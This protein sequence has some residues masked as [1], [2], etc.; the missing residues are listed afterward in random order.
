M[1]RRDMLIASASIA[2][3]NKAAI[4]TSEFPKSD[5]SIRYVVPFAPGGLT[6]VMARTVAQK[7]AEAWRISVVVENKAGASGQIGAEQVA[8]SAS[9][10]SNLLAITSNHAVNVALFPNATY[11]LVKDLRPVALLANSPM[12][13]VVPASSPLNDFRDLMAASKTRLLA[14]GSSSNGSATHLTMALFNDVNQ[15][16]MTHV[17]YKG[18]APSMLDLIS[19]RLDVIFSNFPESIAHVKAGKLRALAICSSARHHVVPD[20][21]TTSE[22]GMPELN[23]ESWT[24]VMLP[25]KAPDGV[26]DRYSREISRIMRMADVQERVKSQGF[27]LNFQ[28]PEEFAQFLTTEISRWGRIIK[29]GNISP[30]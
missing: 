23:V 22:A 24:G 25:A 10:G 15:T 8:R 20:V 5:T 28:G 9:D 13:V 19:G 16:Q 17:P 14:A 4:A 12:L 21:P 2:L 3:G 7:L 6:D 26:V 11:N 30:E 18:G 29:V 27:R 1:K